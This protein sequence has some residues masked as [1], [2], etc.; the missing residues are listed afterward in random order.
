M[1]CLEPSSHVTEA[2]MQSPVIMSPTPG[3]DMCM[4]HTVLNVKTP[5]I[6]GNLYHIVTHLR[7]FHPRALARRIA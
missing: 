4:C 1:L 5:I 3:T 7:P 6:L 2:A